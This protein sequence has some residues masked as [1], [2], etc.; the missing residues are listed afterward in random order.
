MEPNDISLKSFNTYV[1]TILSRKKNIEFQ[2]IS[3]KKLKVLLLS[4]MSK[5]KTIKAV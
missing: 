4:K 2:N 1:L 5:S 3:L